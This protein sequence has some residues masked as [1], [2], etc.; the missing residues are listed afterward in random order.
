T[1]PLCA[2]VVTGTL[3]GT[4]RDPSGQVISGATITAVLRDRNLERTTTTN[5]AGEYELNFLPVGTYRLTASFTG[6]N[7]QT[8]EGLELR[9][10]QRTRVDFTLQLG[11]VSE[12]VTVTGEVPLVNADS[13]NIG[14][15]IEQSRVLELPVKARQFIDL[16]TLAAGVTPEVSGTF[17]SQ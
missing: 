5:A 4:V 9:I 15:V 6:F 7:A 11:P 12:Q 1:P 10:D 3:L 16:M 17:G 14:E 13:S 8:Q 2:Q